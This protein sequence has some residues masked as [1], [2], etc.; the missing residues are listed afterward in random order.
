MWLRD[1]AIR[2]YKETLRV[3]RVALGADHPDVV[4][5]LQHIG[6]VLQQL[7]DLNG[8]LKYF[9]EALEIE[10]RRG[11]DQISVA[12]ILNCTLYT[13]PSPRDRHKTSMTHSA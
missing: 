7:G 11:C 1:R 4:L 13:S 3:E 9:L 12:K 2:L 10:R 8:A 6:Q 5:T